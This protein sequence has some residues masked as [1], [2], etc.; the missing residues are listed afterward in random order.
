MNRD[1]VTWSGPMPA[2]TT[3]FD[4]EGRLDEAGSRANVE[5]LLEAAPTGFVAGGCTGEF[6]A[7]SLAERKTLAQRPFGRPEAVA[8]CW[9]A[10]AR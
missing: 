3:P 1:S 4:G 10:R 2:L 6:W 5:R 9:W 8:R 7:L